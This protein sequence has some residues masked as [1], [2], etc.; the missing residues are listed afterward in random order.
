MRCWGT[1]C[2]RL[3]NREYPRGK[4]IPN[5]E[6]IHIKIHVDTARL[7]K[8]NAYIDRLTHKGS[9][10]NRTSTIVRVRNMVT[11]M[12]GIDQLIGATTCVGYQNFDGITSAQS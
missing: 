11:G 9:Q 7:L 12:D 6:V 3:R 2:C 5:L 4:G 1:G 8:L 10:G